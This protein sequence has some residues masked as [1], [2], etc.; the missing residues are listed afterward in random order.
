MKTIII[1]FHSFVDVITNSSTTIFVGCHDNTIKY[2]KELIDTLLK[3]MGS[4]KK[5]DDLFEFEVQSVNR[6]DIIDRTLTDGEFHDG[7][8]D[9]ELKEM[10]IDMSGFDEMEEKKQEEIV[11]KIVDKILAGELD[12]ESNE[13]GYDERQLIIK[14]KNDSKEVINLNDYLG[15]IF[16]I[17][18][19]RDG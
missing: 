15:R 4:D 16:E 1:P 11:N 12:Y 6:D 9:D 14:L 13:Y 18:G 17:D 19:T 2:A 7:E 3:T 10:G 8:L 5:A